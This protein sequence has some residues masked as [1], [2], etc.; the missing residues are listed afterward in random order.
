MFGQRSF[1]VVVGAVLQ[2]AHYVA[3]A[4]MFRVYTDV[5]DALRRY[6]FG[7]GEYPVSLGVKTPIGTV[8]A[9]LYSRYDMLTLNEIFCRK[10][11]GTSGRLAV[12]L[13]IGSNIGL[14]ALYFLTRNRDAQCYL[15]EPDPKNLARLRLQLAN[16][17]S[18]YVLSGCAIADR[19]G[20][21]TFGVEP[22][23]RY[24]GIDVVA[25]EHITVQC[26]H[27]NRVLAEILAQHPRID[28][29]K[30]DTEGV[31]IATVKAMD[32]KLAARVG[33]IYIE[34]S[35]SEDI[36]PG[37]F[38]QRQYGSIARLTIRELRPVSRP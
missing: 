12:V 16:F 7:K 13:D 22:I 37:Q 27:I 38:A 4:N 30:I 23:G 10:D 11:Y 17:T 6:L 21:V 18:R 28:L 32:A 33:Q 34:A 29:I 25:D 19:E 1:T 24:G 8:Q 9:R 26:L 36:R 3:F 31:E 14:S 2:G 15:F 20:P 35:P 5:P